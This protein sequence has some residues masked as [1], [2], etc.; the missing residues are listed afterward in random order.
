MPDNVTPS[1]GQCRFLKSQA[2]ELICAR[3]P[4]RPV[5]G[6]LGIGIF[7]RVFAGWQCGEFQAK[8]AKVEERSYLGK[9][10]NTA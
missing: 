10:E 7:P 9:S 6:E 1:C 5:E 4:P 8:L 2:K 3:Y